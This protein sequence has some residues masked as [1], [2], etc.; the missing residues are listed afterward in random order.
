M[1]T[2]FKSILKPKIEASIPEA[3]YL[4]V[5]VSESYPFVFLRWTPDKDA[6]GLEV[7]GLSASTGEV[8]SRQELPPYQTG[9]IVKEDR[10]APMSYLVKATYEPLKL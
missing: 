10:K 7:I 4:D 1:K 2:F 8:R 5:K 3:K 9:L 6:T